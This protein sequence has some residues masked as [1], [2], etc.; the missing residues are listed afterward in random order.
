M[1]P[2]RS[3]IAVGCVPFI[4]WLLVALNVLVFFGELSL[5]P[6]QLEIGLQ[7]YGLVPARFVAH[8]S[9]AQLCTVFS[10]MFLHAGWA[11]VVGNMWFLHIFGN[12]VED[13][14]GHGRY[15]LL[16]LCSG[17][18]A[19]LLQVTIEPRATLP[20]IGASG[21]IAG[22]LGAHLVFFPRATV[23]TFIFAGLLSRVA[24]IPCTFYLL[25][26]FVLQVFSGLFA[27]FG[28]PDQGAAQVA[29]WAHSGG[30]VSGMIAARFF[31]AVEDSD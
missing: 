2:L 20:M 19:A 25:F 16:Y 29:F 23:S 17:I 30:F 4:T 8:L 21:A 3:S 6:D 13:R 26:W 24:E 1:F 22:V 28:T 12:S 11:H 27:I 15:M 31:L 18:C 5:N 7:L 10:A 14:V 9:W